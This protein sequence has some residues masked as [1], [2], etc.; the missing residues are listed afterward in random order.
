MTL[1]LDSSSDPAGRAVVIDV[2][3][4]DQSLTSASRG[5]YVGGTG[6]VKVD[7]A[8]GDTGIIF[9]SVPAG[10]ILPIQVTKIYTSGTS[11]T[12]MVAMW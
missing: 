7:M 5:L 9:Q 11:A 4:V 2:S 6:N 10:A 12:K 3:A 1:S 8:G